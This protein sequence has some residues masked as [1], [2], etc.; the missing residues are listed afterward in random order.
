MDKKLHSYLKHLRCWCAACFVFWTLL[1]NGSFVLLS[2]S[3]W[4]NLK[5]I[6]REIGLTAIRKDYI[7]QLWNSGHGGVLAAANSNTLINP[8]KMTREAYLLEQERFGIRGNIT[9]LRLLDK[10]NHPD[11]WEEA[12]LRR[13]DAGAADVAEMISKGGQPYMRVMIPAVMDQSC[14]K[15]HVEN[16]YPPGS[17]RGGIS[18]TLP[19]E[20][21]VMLFKEQIKTSLFYHLLIYLIGVAGL[22]IFYFQTSRQFSR[23]AAVEER[24]SVQEQHLRGIV[25]N[26]SNGIAVYETEDGENFRLKRINPAGMRIAHI[27]S[28]GDMAGRS[29]EEIF[30]GFAET[31]L[32]E[33]FRRVARSGE[34]E[35]LSVSSCIHGKRGEE[36]SAPPCLEYYV[37]KLPTGEIVAVYEDVTSRK[38]AREQLIRKTEEWESTFDAIPDI[39]TLQDKEMRII[40]ANQATFEFFHLPPDKLIGKTCHSLFR[41]SEQPCEGCPGQRA[42]L[43][44]QKHCGGIEHKNISRFFNICAAP[45][46][47]MA[48]E[49]LYFVYIAHDVTD[50]KK[51]EE[52]LFQAQKMEAI[53]T[54]AGGIAHDFNNILAAILGYAELARMELPEGSSAS[55]DLEQVIIAGNRATELVKQIL[56]FSRKNAHQKKPLRIHL[57]VKEAVKM[58]R[59]S[60]PSSISIKAEIDE[61]SGLALADPTN[62]HQIVLNLCA[63]ASHAIGSRQGNLEIILKRTELTAAQREDRPW[64]Q[65]GFYIV[66]T[67]RDDGS[68][69]DEKTKARIFDPYFTTKEQGAGTGLGL[70]VTLGVVEDCGGFIEVESELGKGAAFHVHLPALPEE[71]IEQSDEEGEMPLPGGSERILVVDDEP[72]IVHISQAILSTLGYTVMAETSSLA[73]LERLQARPDAFDLLLTD[74]TMPGLTGSE[75]VKAALQLRPDLP[76]ILCTGYTTALTEKEALG[77]GVRRYAIKPLNTAKLAALVREV[78]DEAK[79]QAQP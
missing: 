37:Y 55:G 23:R 14:F 2:F 6:G 7:Y 52:E 35:N 38:K 63:N 26:I 49:F 77:L 58:L 15:C 48:G 53:G 40:R 79:T 20:E 30:P 64:L 78:L 50:K 5:F 29:P 67:V 24:L 12:A 57:I 54:L 70:A 21:T 43:D 25:D 75:L 74:Q 69:M 41:G 68:G 56:T 51:L 9:S 34:P 62:I 36:E 22:W 16:N 47:N 71:D 31:G 46:M 60:L 76:T 45:V 61:K 27:E 19:M 17:I 11:P 42:M 3:E 72:S 32:A 8:A 39:I 65:P 4:S 28:G 44:L 13:F 18:V 33:V 66:L 73:A 10:D 1:L 59:S